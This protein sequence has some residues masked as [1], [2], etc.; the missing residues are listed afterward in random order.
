M[1]FSNVN[2]FGLKNEVTYFLKES[3][4]RSNFHGFFFFFCDAFPFRELVI[5]SHHTASLL[6]SLT[7]H[8]QGFRFHC[9]IIYSSL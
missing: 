8:V 5:L 3:M 1:L 7:M 2:P 6:F 4:W 9:L